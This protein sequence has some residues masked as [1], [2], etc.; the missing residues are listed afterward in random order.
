MHGFEETVEDQHVVEA[1]VS[2]SLK[3]TIENV[4]EAEPELITDIRNRDEG[5]VLFCFCFDLFV[6]SFLKVK[7]GGIFFFGYISF[8][9]FPL[10]CLVSPRHRSCMTV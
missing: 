2:G 4:N 8:V 10:K 9:F 3:T 6:C 7:G 1:G 5:L